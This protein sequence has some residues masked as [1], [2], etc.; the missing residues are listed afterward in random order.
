MSVVGIIPARYQSSRF[1][2]KPLAGIHG[3]P[4]IQHVYE[5]ASLTHILDRLLIATDDLRILEA[6]R[7]FGCECLLTRDDHASGTDRVAEVCESLDLQDSEIIVNIQG[8]EPLLLPEMI[9][10]LVDTLCAHAESCMATLAF[11]SSNR[12]EY[13][14]TNVV[15]VVADGN[16]K[17]L[18][19]SRSPVPC[20]RDGP[21]AELKFLKH[22]GF[23]AYRCE[24]LRLF[25]RLPQGVLE[26]T[27]KLEQLRA[28]EHGYPIFVALTT[29]DTFGIDT[30]ED[31]KV[32]LEHQ[33]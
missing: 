10:Q 13:F 21:A 20:F 3:K 7:S 24:F 1:P 33:F 12:Q 4:M 5:R 29:A 9:E 17:A 25:T 22:L 30:P 15:K 14:D 28:L 16:G 26:T 19:F 31:L 11:S 8:D 6:A 27:E 23:Y 2:G 18:Y 32:L